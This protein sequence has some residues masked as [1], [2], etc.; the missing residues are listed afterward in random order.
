MRRRVQEWRYKT[1]LVGIFEEVV[2]TLKN[3][4]HFWLPVCD[5]IYKKFWKNELKFVISSM[6]M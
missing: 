1:N 3:F 2:K 6:I 5:K 4:K